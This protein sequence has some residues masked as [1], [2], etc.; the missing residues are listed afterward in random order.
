MFVQVETTK[1]KTVDVCLQMHHTSRLETFGNNVP[2]LSVTSVRAPQG[3]ARTSIYSPMPQATTRSCPPLVRVSG[4]QETSGET[5]LGGFGPKH[6]LL[7][8]HK[9]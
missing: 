6:R 9:N 4:E 5:F 3:S 1:Q 8:F 7:L 2:L